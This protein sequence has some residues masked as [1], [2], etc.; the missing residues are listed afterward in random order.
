M[1]APELRAILLASLATSEVPKPSSFRQGASRIRRCFAIL[2]AF[3]DTRQGVL[4]GLP[5]IGSVVSWKLVQD[6]RALRKSSSEVRFGCGVRDFQEIPSKA[7]RETRATRRFWDLDRRNP[8]AK[9]SFISHNCDV[10]SLSRMLDLIESS[11]TRESFG[12]VTFLLELILEATGFDGVI[13]WL[14]WSEEGVP[15]AK[16]SDITEPEPFVVY[17]AASFFRDRPAERIFHRQTSES[18]TAKGIKNRSEPWRETFDLAALPE[19]TLPQ[20]R[21]I[22]SHFGITEMGAVPFHISESR[23]NS[24]RSSIVGS[25]NFY[26]CG[27]DRP[28]ITCSV[29]ETLNEYTRLFS[30]AFVNM[31]D[32]VG[33]RFIEEIKGILGGPD[34]DLKINEPLLGPTVREGC[35]RI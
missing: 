21:Q 15:I 3:D 8:V 9:P 35:A 30:F 22:I 6:T 14:P 29:L 31:V 24:W 1:R 18:K 4:A 13:L 26:L 19:E 32:A 27:N 2:D 25:L 5:C 16:R 11:Q 20:E 28:P 17:A 33:L 12:D 7:R 10:H 34:T 23:E